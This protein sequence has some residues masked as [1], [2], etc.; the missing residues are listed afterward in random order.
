MSYNKDTDYQAKINEA[1]SAGDYKK[2]AEYEQSRNEK[3]DGESLSYQKTNNYAVWTE[4]TDYAADIQK[5][6]A[7]G[8]SR[9]AVADNLEKRVKKA[10][11]T[12][13][14]EKYAYD[15]TYNAAIEYIMGSG[16]FSYEKDAP[17]Y[18]NKY[19]DYTQRLLK[20][21]T[22]RESFSYNPYEDDLYKYYR[23]EY[24]KAG[25]RA[26]EDSLG[27]L[28]ANTGGVASS[29]AANAAGQAFN[30][31][32]TQLSQIIPELYKLHYDEYLD[33]VEDDYNRL[34]AL[35]KLSDSQ[36]EQ[37]LNQLSAYQKDRDFSYGVYSD[38]LA[39][40]DRLLENNRSY[41]LSLK[42]LAEEAEQNSFERS[43]KE[44]ENMLEEK[45]YNDKLA[46]EEKQYNEKM[47]LEKW[48]TLGYLD[49]A[50]ADILGLPYGTRTSDYD[51]KQA[52]KYKI[53]SK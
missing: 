36:Y 6:I 37:Y 5:Q 14:M 23:D 43:Q 12:I 9:S 51:Y 1:V 48:D 22:N 27:K 39:R 42:E 46:L 53:Y 30:Y 21:L 24:I 26:M 2:A 19:D 52:Q 50:S 49:R 20:E 3:I 7:S 10:S 4:K 28:S 34:N 45:R 11:S 16:G 41:E 8:A 47:A 13:G 44:Y 32:N 17:K 33:D 25:N 31:Y 29:Y 38:M 15:D 35:M 18:Q 40:E